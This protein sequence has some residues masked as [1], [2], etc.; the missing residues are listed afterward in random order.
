[1]GQRHQ[2]YLRLPKVYYNANNPN[3]R[4]EKTLGLHHQWLYGRTA[5][6]LLA[7]FALFVEKSREAPGEDPYWMILGGAQDVLNACYTCVPATGY[8]HGVHTLDAECED[9]RRGDNNDGITIIDV[10]GGKLRYCFMSIHHIEGEDGEN[11]PVMQPLTAEQYVTYY[12]PHWKE[13]KANGYDSKT[14][15]NVLMDAPEVR[16]EI[17]AL[18]DVLGKY[19]ALPISRVKKIF[20][21]MFKP[22]E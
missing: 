8:Y 4:P 18:L 20:P 21:K 17:A 11:C 14:G 22:E 9:P 6:Q 13:G 12:Y 19:E 10:T 16:E 3:N 1:M 5:L 2:V 15:K 7:N